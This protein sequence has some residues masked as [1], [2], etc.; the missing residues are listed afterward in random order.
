MST[1][2]PVLVVA[3]AECRAELLAELAQLGWLATAVSD[4][5]AAAQV[6]AQRRFEVALLLMDSSHP[7]AAA[8]FEAC[9]AE[10]AHCEWVGVFPAG[11]C[12]RAPW[13][14]HILTHFFDHH[15]YPANLQ[16]LCQSLG[17]AWGRAALRE[18]AGNDSTRGGDMGM[19]G[20]SPALRRL[21]T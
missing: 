20:E 3:A 8:Q 11:E 10:A 17:H 1:Q 12:T 9:I 15:T 14:D 16:F 18:R 19:V 2:R 5:G 13:R 7:A 4:L 21:R 6:L